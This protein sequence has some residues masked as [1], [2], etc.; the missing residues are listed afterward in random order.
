M[1]L[2]ALR[3]GSDTRCFDELVRRYRPA[4]LRFC[5]SYL[6][7]TARAED[8]VQET[9]GKLTDGAALP[10]DA[11]KPW[12]YRIARNR[13]L[14]ILRRQQR[15]PTHHGRQR[16]GFDAPAPTAGPRTRMAR[17]ERRA[18]IRQIVEQMPEEYRAVLM[19]KYFEG[20][21]R[22]EIAET[23]GVSEAAVKGRIV[24]ASE[25]LE[26]RLREYTWTE[27]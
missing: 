3:Q 11:L 17:A 4:L 10:E 27:P 16:T 9:F 20:F 2:A 26:N 21:S 22:A 14:D 13:C 8:V 1:L 12:L 18:L 7:D 19:L 5:V 6:T 15:S 25:Y 23:L 24:R